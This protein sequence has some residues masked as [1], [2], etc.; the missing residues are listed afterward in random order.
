MNGAIADG[1][2]G[3]STRLR[4]MEPLNA[5]DL[6]DWFVQPPWFV[7]FLDG[8]LVAR[9]TDRAN[10]K[11]LWDA[12]GTW[13]PHHG[14]RVG[15]VPAADVPVMWLTSTTDWEILPTRLMTLADRVTLAP[16]ETVY[17]SEPLTID[18]E[19]R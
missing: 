9:I 2:G 8:V 16:V 12:S 14:V 3:R 5:A 11:R 6:P 4:P 19:A 18:V 15:F 7:F 13:G 1:Y 10:A 17:G